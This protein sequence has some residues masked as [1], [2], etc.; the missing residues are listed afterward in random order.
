MNTQN[1]EGLGAR[2]LA[3][4]L[5]EISQGH[6]PAKR[7]LCLELAGAPGSQDVARE[8]Y[9]CLATIERSRSFID[10]QQRK[11]LVKNFET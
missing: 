8:V 4:L 6:G 11:E 7:R 9:K 2:R 5:I 10:W 3:A 1:L